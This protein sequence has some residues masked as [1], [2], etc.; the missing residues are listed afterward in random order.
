MVAATLYDNFS[1]ETDVLS[2]LGEVIPSSDTFNGG[3]I[4]GGFLSALFSV[5]LFRNF[6]SIAG[7]LGVIIFGIGSMFLIFVGSCTLHSCS[8]HEV[9]A[10]GFFVSMPIALF[11]MAVGYFMEKRKHLAYWTSAI[12]L[13]ALAF[14]VILGSPPT[15]QPISFATTEMSFAT[16][17]GVWTFTAGLT[18][19]KQSRSKSVSKNIA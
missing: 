16:T 4:V 11:L 1:W 8:P 10:T 2:E 13:T 9:V 12:A 17:V 19:I 18:L 3:I 6:S 5:G 7:K 15:Q 14:L